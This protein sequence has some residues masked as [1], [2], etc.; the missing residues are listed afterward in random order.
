MYIYNWIVTSFGN[1]K[2][3]FFAKD[4]LTFRFLAQN[5][6]DY[7]KI[8]KQGSRFRDYIKTAWYEQKFP[9]FIN[10]K[11]VIPKID[12][13]VMVGIHKVF[14]QG[15]IFNLQRDNQPEFLFHPLD[16]KY[17][18][19]MIELTYKDFCDD[20]DGIFERETKVCKVAEL[21]WK[22]VVLVNKADEP[23]YGCGQSIYA[24]PKFYE[25]WIWPDDPF[26]ASGVLPESPYADTTDVEQK[27]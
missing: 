13:C 4:Y 26:A 23:I 20:P 1:R 17:G 7:N 27:I 18:G 16:W 21:K 11:F 19:S 2:K 5:N 6:F 14:S 24:N 8:E 15:S 9:T 22:P 12:K 3:F 25:T 10:D